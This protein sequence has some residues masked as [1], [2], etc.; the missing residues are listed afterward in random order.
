M[1]T[2]I[3]VLIS[4]STPSGLGVSLWYLS[5]KCAQ[6][7]CFRCCEADAFLSLCILFKFVRDESAFI[8]LGWI[9]LSWSF[10]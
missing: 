7:F 4:S 2:E 8:E 1:T 10:I 3:V 9:D 6:I 5:G